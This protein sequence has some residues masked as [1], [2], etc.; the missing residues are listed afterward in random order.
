MVRVVKKIVNHIRENSRLIAEVNQRIMSLQYSNSELLFAQYFRDSIQGSSWIY[1]KSFSAYGGAANY[2]LLYKLFKIYDIIGPMNVLEFG[3]GQTTKMSSQ[4]ALANKKSSILVIDDDKEWVDIYRKQTSIPDNMKLVVLGLQDFK[5]KSTN[6]QKNSEYAK[7]NSVIDDIKFNL[8]IVD[9]PVGW[10]KDY[11]RTNVISLVD[12]LADDWIVVFDDAE[13]P[14][15][16]RTID[17]FRERLD[18]AN[19]RY[20]E[21]EVRGGKAQYYFCSPG[22]YKAVYAI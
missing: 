6:L 7:L 20:S 5:Y 1:D 16:R 10:D 18:V 8:I 3:L 11:P 14:G 21:F 19:M 2:S 12:S 9:G 13:R 22:L 4:Y 15:E 17:L